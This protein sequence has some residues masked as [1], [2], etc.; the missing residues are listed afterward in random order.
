MDGLS[1]MKVY[2]KYTID[3]TYLPSNYPN[4]LEFIIKSINNTIDSNKWTTTLE[5]MAIPKNP[6]G[7]TIAEGPAEQASKN[8]SR[9][10]QASPTGADKQRIIEK[11]IAFA[12]SK[13]ITDKE[14]LTAILAT[15]KAESNFNPAIVESFNYSLDSAKRVFPSYFRGM[16]DAQILQY[17]PVSKGGSGSQEK[18]A[19]FLYG[20]K[21]GNGPNEG[22]KYAGK[23]LV[24][25]TFKG[26]YE[27]M[28]K[29][30]KY[31]G[32]EKWDIVTN[33]EYLNEEDTA[34]AVLVIGKLPNPGGKDTI[35]GLS[36]SKSSFGLQLVKGFQGYLTD[37]LE[38]QAT[39]NGGKKVVNAVT[40]GYT[41]AVYSI[42]NTKYIQ[43]LIA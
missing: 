4:S 3:T 27:A 24:Q 42:N 39:Q 10:T 36:P 14:R 33:P 25:I 28:A 17:I 41:S 21:Y 29:K 37:G 15:A 32:Y 7:S 30:L 13:G 20:G 6:Y 8:A 31:Y 35:K 1:G 23:G 12:K 11:I 26:N 5:S 34:I 16:T 38:V 40:A 19:N 22:Y 2:Q 9:G 18:L 43:D